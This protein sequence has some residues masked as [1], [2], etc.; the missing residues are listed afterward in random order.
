[1]IECVINISEGRD[2]VA[3]RRLEEACAN[4]LL[5][6]HTDAD[7]N[8]S[9]F[10][11][12]GSSLFEDLCALADQAALELDISIHSGVHPRL[13]VLD[14]VPFIP[15][16]ES[17]EAEAQLMSL[18]FASYLSDTLD[19]PTFLYGN[20]RTLPWVRKHAFVDLAPDRGPSQPHPHLGASVVGVRDP[21][22]AFNMIVD[23]TPQAAVELARELR[24]GQLRVLVF[25][26]GAGTQFST[27]LIAPLQY[28][29]WDLYE[30][31]RSR[32]D[33]SS[34]ELV[35]LVPKAVLNNIKRERWDLLDLSESRTIEARISSKNR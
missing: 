20:S 8:R 6:I 26:V 32:V 7:H 17:S 35:G 1:M 9:V 28:G 25:E 21:L 11:L 29:P 3:I 34:C 22:V 13:G 5:D 14:V 30:D 23:T 33:V 16:V 27:N 18:R 12:Y 15:L 10:T 31:V 2:V 4:S 19:I 24:S